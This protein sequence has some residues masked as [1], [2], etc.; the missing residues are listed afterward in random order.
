MAYF[1][2]LQRY[3]SLVGLFSCT[4]ADTVL[5][6]LPGD[7]R[8]G[9]KCVFKSEKLRRNMR[10]RRCLSTQTTAS[11]KTKQI[12]RTNKVDNGGWR[13]SLIGQ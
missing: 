8:E 10:G 11:A 5:C 4:H 2:F 3:I 12:G 9:F 13:F 7:L 1:A 6:R